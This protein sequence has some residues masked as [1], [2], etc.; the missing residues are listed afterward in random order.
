MKS[1]QGKAMI[2]KV[3][4]VILCCILVVIFTIGGIVIYALFVNLCKDN[5]P[6]STLIYMIFIF[7]VH[8]A[9]LIGIATLLY[10]CS[11]TR[12]TK[13]GGYADKDQKS[14]RSTTTTASAHQE[15]L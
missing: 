11:S 4:N 10:Q 6:T 13:S 15:K 2:R 12:K 1:E 7:C 8:C 3:Q 9:E 5:G 14:V